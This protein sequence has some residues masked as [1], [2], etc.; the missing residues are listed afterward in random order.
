MTSSRTEPTK[1]PAKETTT[2]EA[3]RVSRVG[4]RRGKRNATAQ[5]K[6]R[7]TSAR[8]G[9]KTAKILR[10]LQRPSGASLAELTKAS[11]WQPH[12]VRGF[13]SGAVRGKMRLKISSM[14]RE[15]GERAYR[16]PS[17]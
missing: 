5:S 7:S 11:G 1:V 9:T 8:P 3:S 17:K 15:D 14:K 13:L 6:T 10:L 16:L 12:S 2:T 4:R